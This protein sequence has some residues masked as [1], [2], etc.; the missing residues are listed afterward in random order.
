MG[1]IGSE[2]MVMDKTDKLLTI[3]TLCASAWVG[4]REERKG[5]GREVTLHL[6]LLG[7]KLRTV[8][9]DLGIWWSVMTTLRILHFVAVLPD[10]NLHNQSGLG[11]N[12]NRKR[13]VGSNK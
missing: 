8:T 3:N 5:N 2:E 12:E 9:T 11:S 1:A 13:A 10:R 6:L 4:G 7:S